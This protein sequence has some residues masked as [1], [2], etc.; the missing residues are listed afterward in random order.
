M[1]REKRDGKTGSLAGKLKIREKMRDT[2]TQRKAHHVEGRENSRGAM[3][4]VLEP[5][6]RL[7]LSNQQS[8]VEPLPHLRPSVRN[9][10]THTYA[11]NI[12]PCG[13]QANKQANKRTHTYA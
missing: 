2:P 12:G 7:A 3:V 1:G 6:H 10:Q 5:R 4:G 11:K 13:Q 8:R 9:T